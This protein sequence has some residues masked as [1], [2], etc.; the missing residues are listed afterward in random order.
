MTCRCFESC[1]CAV[2]DD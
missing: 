2:S 1:L